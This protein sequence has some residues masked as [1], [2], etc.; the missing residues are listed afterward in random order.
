MN[1]WFA[2]FLGDW[3]ALLVLVIAGFLPNEAWRMIGLWLGGGVDDRRA[4][5]RQR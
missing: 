1:D 3:H 4:S 2:Q 5:A